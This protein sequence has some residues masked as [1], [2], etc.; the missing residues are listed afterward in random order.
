[1]LINIIIFVLWFH[2]FKTNFFLDKE[3]TKKVIIPIYGVIIWFIISLTP[4]LNTL[5]FIVTIFLSI[6]FCFKTESNNYREYDDPILYYK[7]GKIISF[8]SKE[9]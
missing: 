4:I 2:T 1:M 9:L 3:L 5:V 6:R 7:K 8:L